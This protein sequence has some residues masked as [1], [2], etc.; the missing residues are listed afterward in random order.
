M[1]K[2]CEAHF[3]GQA[4]TSDSG[5]QDRT[6]KGCTG[7]FSK[8]LGSV[9]LLQ[10]PGNPSFLNLKP[11]SLLI[12]S[13]FQLHHLAVAVGEMVQLSAGRFSKGWL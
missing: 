8:A 10:D 11:E 7:T 1:G 13:R 12:Y 3:Q 5:L 9:L 6:G 4:M 2:E